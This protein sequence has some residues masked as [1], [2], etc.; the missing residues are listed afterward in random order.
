MTFRRITVSI[1]IVIV[2]ILLLIGTAV[3]LLQKPTMQSLAVVQAANYLSHKM[4]T[5]VSIGG[6]AV[7]ICSRI[8]LTDL[9]IEDWDCDTLLFTKQLKVDIQHLALL[10]QEVLV[11]GISLNEPYIRMRRDKGAKWHNYQY[12]LDRMSGKS[13]SSTEASPK[14][15]N[16][17]KK[18]SADTDTTK[19]P[20]P[21]KL[22]LEYL[23]INKPH[24]FMDDARTR[25]KLTV[26]LNQ[27]NINLNGLDIDKQHVDIK[28]ALL[29]QVNVVLRIA[30]RTEPKKPSDK[31]YDYNEYVSIT[32]PNWIF[33]AEDLHLKEGF[34]SLTTGRDTLFYED[35]INFNR[36]EV[37][38][39]DVL[40]ENVT[41]GNNTYQGKILNF[42]AK[43]KSGFVVT[44]SNAD[45]VFSGNLLEFKNLTLKTPYSDLGNH[46]TFRYKSLRNFY[47]FV[48]RVKLEADF[49]NGTFVFQDIIYFARALQKVKPIQNKRFE[50]IKIN[51]KVAGKIRRI[52]GEDL[53]IKIQNTYLK[54][55]VSMSGLPD[56]DNTFIDF[57]VAALKTDISDIRSLLPDV[58]IPPNF[59]KLGTL[60]FKGYFTG[61]PKA[62][63][64]EGAL[65]TD[66]GKVN[67]DLVMDMKTAIAKYSGDLA[68]TDFE[69]GEWL[70]NG[71]KEKFGKVSFDSKIKGQG[72]SLSELDVAVD[73]QLKELTFNN[74]TYQNVS[75]DGHFKQKNFKGKLKTANNDLNVDFNGEVDLNNAMPEYAFEAEFKTINL[76]E[77]NLINKEKFPKEIIFSGKTNLKL[78]GTNIDNITGKA[79]FNNVV[80]QLGDKSVKVKRINI[81]STKENE[82]REVD[83]KSS[84]L[85]AHFE[86]DFDFAHVVKAFNNYLHTYF[87]Y[88]FKDRGET[89]PQQITFDL[90]L[91]KGVLPLVQMFVPQ[92][93]GFKNA[94][95]KG[96]FNTKTKAMD[97][98]ANIKQVVVDGTQINNFRLIGVSD[99]EQIEFSTDV[100]SVV[101]TKNKMLPTIP[102]IHLEGTIAQN[103]IDFLLGVAGEEA[104]N[105]LSMGGLLIATKDILQ[106]NLDDTEIVI[107]DKTWE[108]Q[109]GIFTY[110]DKNSFT[111]EHLGLSEGN[112]QYITIQSDA[113]DN[114]HN[115]TTI[116]LQGIDLGDFE[117]IPAIRNLKLDANIN[118]NVTLANLFSDQIIEATISAN[119]FHILGQAL[120]NVKAAAKK[121]KA[122]EKL[123]LNL[124]VRNDKYNL[125]VENNPEN[126]VLI[127]K[128]GK[129]EFNVDLLIKQGDLKFIHAFVGD[130][131]SETEGKVNGKLEVRGDV[132]KPNLYGPLNVS[133]R[134]KVNYLQT[135]YHF[136]DQ[137]IT[138]DEKKIKFAGATIYDTYQSFAKVN[139]FIDLND[140]KNVLMDV[141]LS[142]DGIKNIERGHKG[143]TL[144][145]IAIENAKNILKEKK[146]NNRRDNS[147]RDKEIVEEPNDFLFMDTK[148]ADNEL[149]YG[150]A[151]GQGF[152][153]IK[154]PLN[155]LKMYVNAQSGK[156]TKI[157]LPISY[158]TEVSQASFYTFINTGEKDTTDAVDMKEKLKFSGIDID[159]DLALT[160]DA[161]IQIIFDLQA[162]DI[163]KSRGYGDIQIQ[164]KTIGDFIF[165]VFGRY[166]IEKGNYL[167]TLQNVVNK[168]FIIKKGSTMTF[169][170]DP[171]QA[172][173]DINSLY[174]LRTS[175]HDLFNNAELLSLENEPDLRKRIPIDVDLSLRGSLLNPTVNFNI[176]QPNFSNSRVDDLTNN[177]IRTMVNND[178]NELNKQIFG[179]LVLNQ[180]MPPEEFNFDLR[181]GVNTTVSELLS[182]YVSNYLNDAIQLDGS[183]VN[184]NWRNYNTEA[185]LGD[186]SSA[187]R[188]EIGMDF[189][190]RMWDDRLTFK[191]GGNVDVGNKVYASENQVAIAGDFLIEYSITPDGKYK[192]KA[193]NRYDDDMFTGDYNKVGASIY[194]TQEF[195][196][197]K[198]LVDKRKAQKERNR[199]KRARKKAEKEKE[200]LKENEKLNGL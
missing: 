83:I 70:G 20:F 72:L 77:L 195:D 88:T 132:N 134:T 31:V 82:Q 154:G 103:E 118:G 8:V 104:P 159:F 125:L 102:D 145:E 71:N 51:G 120:G 55:N 121:E 14:K 197:L 43:E 73:G 147:N 190:Q 123:Y 172:Q 148:F 111:I 22:D 1:L 25:T 188:N 176:L 109:T 24:F 124:M 75:I 142:A 53:A 47:D 2:T 105:R 115:F 92:L 13:P 162:G 21:W 76:H 12:L 160:P 91:R 95:A 60:Q 93:Q 85:N 166:T 44:K 106:L 66:I 113:T 86:G 152:I 135:K 89:E 112:K 138:F 198:E 174:G 170:G 163:I 32:P 56:F 98:N 19:A 49:H 67:T 133:G 101:I 185:E 28:D 193:F 189:S 99:P 171:Y 84:L 17:T 146:N 69:L 94:N 126:Y 165:E 15:I 129:P 45:A 9:Y 50:P 59:N 122:D 42:A 161:E 173:L 196:N 131:I 90:N 79:R 6:V 48:K 143:K 39:I 4:E 141:K 117:S 136:N 182:N 62:F 155:Q 68:V 179:L 36:M 114:F 156:G 200:K 108:A 130:L 186:G 38:D 87:P 100:D 144:E 80:F 41:M 137:K 199:L 10:Q 97:I 33:T 116:T 27:L 168:Y 181:S 153:T 175:R 78:K 65:I 140:Y 46:L 167:F 81:K 158:D 184:V 149:F 96:M 178:K 139:G 151:K 3:H 107:N 127:P 5:E 34:F 16:A 119:N 74:Y 61:Y 63:S 52:K 191:V 150:I 57:K 18:T 194:V 7:D 58:K 128:K 169:N 29:D 40:L 157:F 110:I 180:F 192:L 23:H 177:K 11:Q 35:A 187:N 183:E 164:V 30:P 26:K 64:A 37:S 54:G